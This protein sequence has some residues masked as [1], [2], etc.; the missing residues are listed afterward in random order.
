MHPEVSAVLE[1]VVTDRRALHRIPEPAREERLTAA[2]LA[3]TLHELGLS[4]R[5]NI[6]G[7]GLVCDL[8]PLEPEAGGQRVALRADMDGIRVEERTGLPFSSVHTGL[9]HACGHDGHLA[10]LLGAARIFAAHPPRRLRLRLLF[11]PAEEQFGGAR[12]LIADGALDGVNR[13]FGA[14]LWSWLPT[15]TVAACPGPMMAQTERFTVD[16][17]ARGGHAALPRGTGDALV[18][19]AHLVTALQTAVSRGV[20][21]PA[22][23][24]VCTVGELHA[25]TA[26]NVIAATAQLKGTLR[27]L[28]PEVMETLRGHVRRIAA[29]VAAANDAEARVTFTGGYPALVNHVAEHALVAAAAAGVATFAPA[30]PVM[31][32]E[33]FSYYLQQIP[34]CFFFVGAGDPAVPVER[35]AHHHEPGFDLD[36]RALAVGVSMWHALVRALDG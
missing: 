24:A 14:H 23:P 30:V 34:G 1:R 32:G 7:H 29:G 5:L 28:T 35:R 13:V 6:G 36:E 20:N 22:E 31:A 8:T 33:D 11:Q 25:G 16:V 18:T 27:A 15:G 17:T 9:M 19:A 10:M 4:P 26:P 12:D 3:A 21:P 2:Y